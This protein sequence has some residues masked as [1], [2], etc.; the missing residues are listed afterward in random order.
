MKKKIALSISFFLVVI[1][2]HSQASFT[3]NGSACVN[4]TI[5]ATAS[6]GTITNP[7]Y[8]WLSSPAGVVFSN[9][10]SASPVLTFSAAGNY[11][12]LVVVTSG[13]LISY[14]QNTIN[15]N[16]PPNVMV[17][18][19][20]STVCAGFTATLTA[21]GANNYTWTGSSFAGGV[22]QQSVSVGPGTYTVVGSNGAGCN[23]KDSSITISLSPPLNISVSQS[24]PTTC[25]ISNFPTL[26]KPVT[27]CPFGAATYAWLPGGNPLTVTCA[28]VRPLVTSQYTVIGGTSLCSG[29]AI[30][31]VS[32]IPQFTIAVSPSLASICAG[33]AINLSL[34]QIGLPSNNPYTYSWTEQ[35][36]LL[37]TLNNVLSP[38]V[39]ATPLNN[40]SY[41]ITVADGN[42]CVSIPASLTVNVSPC[43]EIGEIFTIKPF[44]VFPNPF[45]NQL[46]IQSSSTDSYLELKD[47]LGS[48]ILSREINS[49]DGLESI[50]TGDLA[51]GIYFLHIFTQHER[52]QILKI[53]KN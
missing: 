10:N 29:T 16:S 37:T 9:T 19:T 24:S 44:N 3:M 17:V 5:Q 18:T 51:P 33:S 7:S 15:V 52:V 27:L 4:A 20:A 28:T 43:T 53:L 50:K 12:V 30:V 13:T 40:R 49:Q 47:G 41:S 39:I 34:T 46:Y 38:S 25:I 6:S 8:T 26:S 35:D 32:V 22:P 31:T 23:G 2:V 45:D 36:Q 14:A 11:S 42:S 1:S 48:L 21:F